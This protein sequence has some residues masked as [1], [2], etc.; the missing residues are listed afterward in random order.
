MTPLRE[1]EFDRAM[2]RRLAT[3][4][5]M[6]VDTSHVDRAV[7]A[8]ITALHGSFAGRF[9][10]PIVTIAASLF[11]VIAVGIALVQNRPALASAEVMMQMHRDIV[12]GRVPTMQVD[13]MDDVNKAFAAFSAG[14]PTLNAPPEAHMMACC[15]RDVGNKKVGC[16]LLNDAGGA[17]V[18]L[19]IAD[20]DAVRPLNTPPV[21]HNGEIFHVQTSGDLHMVTADRGHHR[22]CL[23][24]ELPVERLMALS[25]GV[26]F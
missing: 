22:V 14:L 6:P 8:Q 16:V 1:D 23:I 19:A 12:S 26:K 15:M 24:G 18:T 3:L 25:D 11:I 10:R 4:G 21:E 17:K 9:L 5:G 20:I 7:R 2:S 13:S